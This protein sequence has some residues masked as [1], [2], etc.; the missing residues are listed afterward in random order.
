MKLPNVRKMFVPDEGYVMFDADLDRADLQV[1][2]WEADD[3]DLKRR[4]RMG[5][6]L[7]ICGALETANLPLPPED[8]LVETHPKYPEYKDKYKNERQTAKRFIHGT[9]YGGSARTMAINCKL[10]VATAELMQDR[11]FAAHPGIRTWHRR[12]ERQ[13]AATRTVRNAFGYRRI[14][15]DRPEGILPEALAWIPQSTVAC[16]INRG[17]MQVELELPEVAVLIQVHDSLV[18]QFRAGQEAR[19][20]PEIRRCLEV[21]VPYPDPLTIPVSINT[22]T[23]SWGHCK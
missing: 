16:V 11:W 9:N 5:V 8:E 4:L 6:D 2:V 12:I 3:A 19:L 22:S 18:G 1:V 10:P 13:L 21:K 14:Y 17:W 23:V 7:H 15:F 20:L